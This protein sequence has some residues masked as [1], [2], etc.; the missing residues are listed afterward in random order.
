[1]LRIASGK[2]HHFWFIAVEKA[3][4]WTV[5][6]WHVSQEVLDQAKTLN[7]K[8]IAELLECRRNDYWP[9]GYEDEREYDKML[10]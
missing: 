6:V 2:R 9:T 4:P 8:K 7:E 3:F 10:Y 1:M 5:G